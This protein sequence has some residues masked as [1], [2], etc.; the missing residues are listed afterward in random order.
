MRNSKL[1]I[2]SLIIGMLVGT[3]YAEDRAPRTEKVQGVSFHIV[4]TTP[5]TGYNQATFNG[6]TYFVAP[7]ATIAADQVSSVQSNAGSL[8]LSGQFESSKANQMGIL[9]DGQLVA[10]GSLALQN[11][12]AT[13]TGLAPEQTQRVTHLLSR[14]ASTP[15]GAAFTV[16]PAGQSNGEYVYD[17]FVQNVPT[18]RTFQVKLEATGGT[19]GSLTATDVRIDKTRPDYV[20]S[21]NEA[22]AEADQGGSRLGGT[23]FSGTVEV[24]APKY[25][26]TWRFR[27]SADA[28][29]TF[30]IEVRSS[31][32]ESFVANEANQNL[33]I[34]AAGT[35]LQI[36]GGKA[37]LSD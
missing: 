34:T 16:V 18:L 32:T 37:R 13:I 30:K 36:G 1:A 35:T 27:P 4:S 17:V 12:Q 5:A 3:A 11:G 8:T 21:G 28:T 25:V 29:G 20:F 22:I 14:K 9:I 7:K 33:P 6:Q 26:G 19:A 24:S 31:N 10:V 23:L 15:T 2:S